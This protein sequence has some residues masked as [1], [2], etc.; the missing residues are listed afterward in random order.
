MNTPITLAIVSAVSL[1]S[2]GCAAGSASG[3]GGEARVLETRADGSRLVEKGGERYVEHAGTPADLAVLESDKPVE[4]SS[5]VL[6]INGMGCPL[7][8][9]N[10][11][12]Q[13]LR[14]PGVAAVKIDMGSG[15]A[16]VTLGKPPRPSPRQIRH[17][18]ED[19][20]LTLVKIIPQ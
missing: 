13:L 7:C 5:L 3:G 11:D 14:L 8:V 17:A 16:A 6:A 1:V 4:T 18:V 15:T 12:R 2:F 19:A 10:V 20:G 9:T